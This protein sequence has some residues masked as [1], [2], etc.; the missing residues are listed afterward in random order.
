MWV[1]SNCQFEVHDCAQEWGFSENRFDLIHVRALY[2]SIA[3]W[4]AFYDRVY[5][6]LKPGGWYE[7]VEYGVDWKTDDNS[8][9]SGHIFHEASTNHVEAGEKMGKTFRILDPQKD[10]IIQAGFVNVIEKRYKMPLRPWAA[11]K[12]LKE[13]GRW[14]LL[15]AYQGIRVGQWR[16]LRGY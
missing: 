16:C 4:P 6:H 3:D 1:L 2:G 12:K 5:A 9:P 7:Q 10:Y 15:E 13:V 8:I 11:D 14:H